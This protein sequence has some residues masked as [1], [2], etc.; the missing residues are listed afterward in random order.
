LQIIG[1]PR[2]DTAV[3]A[4]A[5]AYQAATGWHTR[6]PELRGAPAEHRGSEANDP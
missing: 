3:L 5:A 6:H 1:P 4:A 2:A